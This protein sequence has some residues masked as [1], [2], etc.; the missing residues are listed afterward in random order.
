M[1]KLIAITT[2]TGNVGR[3]LPA[4]YRLAQMNDIDVVVLA[5][6]AQAVAPWAQGGARVHVGRLEDMEFLARATRG[7][8]ALYWATPNSFPPELTM[9]DGY[10]RFAESAAHAIKTNKIARTV[11]L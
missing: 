1:K 7:V 8:N 3:K 11:Q 9:R 10:R 2:P 6:K 4:Y 5:R